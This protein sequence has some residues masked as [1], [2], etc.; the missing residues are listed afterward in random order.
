MSPRS[1]A[2]LTC[3]VTSEVTWLNSDDQGLV[4][5][6]H[7]KH[8]LRPDTLLVSIMASNNETGVRQPIEEIAAVLDRQPPW[9]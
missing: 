4:D 6:E 1:R 2:W 3:P 7:L 8:A 9:N 5:V